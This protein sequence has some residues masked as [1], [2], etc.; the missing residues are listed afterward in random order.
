MSQVQKQTISELGPFLLLSRLGEGAMAAVY[1][2]RKKDS[3]ELVALKVLDPHLVR[4]DSQ[5]L[6]RFKREA[7]AISML[8]HPNIVRA[9]EFGEDKGYCYL[10]MEY[11]DGESLD[12][13]IKRRGRVPEDDA[14]SIA[15]QIANGL[16]EIDRASLVH[17]DIKPSNILITS[18]G[19]VKL[20]DLGIVKFV[21][22]KPSLTMS[23]DLIGS[24]DYISPEMVKGLKKIDIRA[25]IY[26]TGAT[27]YHML[28]GK[29]P[30]EGEHVME[31]MYKHVEAPLP[32]P[33]EIAP[34]L[35]DEIV[36][37]LEKMMAK[38]LEQ[39]YQTPDSLIEDI[40]RLQESR[41]T[42]DKIKSRLEASDVASV[43][44][45]QDSY[46]E[47]GVDS[48]EAVSKPAERGAITKRRY[49]SKTIGPKSASPVSSTLPVVIGIGVLCLLMLIVVLSSNVS[50]RRR[51]DDR[52]PVIKE[53]SPPNEKP[54]ISTL[55]SKE[56]YGGQNAKIDLNTEK[57]S[58][59]FR[60]QD[61][62]SEWVVY[63]KP[64]PPGK[65][66]AL[67]LA[68]TSETQF[69][70]IFFLLDNHHKGI[71]TN[72]TPENNKFNLVVGVEDGKVS[73]IS[74]GNLPN[75]EERILGNE[76]FSI[77]IVG[78]KELEL[79]RIEV[80]IKKEGE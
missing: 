56:W 74:G 62:R 9:V 25:D 23:D 55:K 35:S 11:V 60:S 51:T 36:K 75:T 16:K 22:S 64:I 30:Y 26:S 68:G 12:A 33:K 49:R 52:K 45:K 57:G 39:R 15:M 41:A 54:P 20:T 76:N 69:I 48:S 14:V 40:K 21:G 31:I 58:V 2:A 34:E 66:F 19:V 4:K 79:E 61:P 3:G 44:S 47:E 71:G 78:Q 6:E 7:E 5:F 46:S 29:R 42:E 10:A 8:N 28:A 27:L 59:V 17:R 67:R 38:D 13:V 43:V 77:V 53:P 72:L 80:F 65:N 32:D 70:K 37:I 1:K 63:Y 18:N 50:D 24:P 73:L